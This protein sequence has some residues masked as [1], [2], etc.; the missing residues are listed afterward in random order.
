MLTLMELDG[1]LRYWTE[2]PIKLVL[3]NVECNGRIVFQLF[4]DSPGLLY[5]S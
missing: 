3:Y 4:G 2:G 1:N 5:C